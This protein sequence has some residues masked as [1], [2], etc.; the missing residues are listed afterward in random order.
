MDTNKLHDVY[1]GLGSNLG[2]KE[3]YIH[4]AINKI[5]EKIGKVISLSSFYVTEPVGFVSE[6]SFIN[7]ACHV[8]TPYTPFKILKITKEI[9]V[10]LGRQIKSENNIYHD[11]TIDIDMLMYDSLILNSNNLIL[12][13]PQLHKRDF[14]L[15]PL[16]EIAGEIIHPV[17]NKT[18]QELVRNLE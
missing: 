14:V 5:N 15:L 1:L 18:I 12:P 13:H 3:H 6:N 7:A 2:D 8:K 11:R 4:C 9:E 16:Q 17:F 10:E